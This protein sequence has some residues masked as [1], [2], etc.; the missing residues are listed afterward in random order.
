MLD[1][2]ATIMIQQFNFV[3]MKLPWI[4]YQ[5]HCYNLL[6]LDCYKSTSFPDLYK[7]LLIVSLYH[8]H[9]YINRLLSIKSF[10][11]YVQESRI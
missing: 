4:N 2:V 8:D 7:K 5:G 9:D 3:F 11:N 10:R 6:C 1:I